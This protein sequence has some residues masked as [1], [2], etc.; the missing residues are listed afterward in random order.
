MKGADV[1]EMP[2]EAA[3]RHAHRLRQRLGLQRRE[4][5]GGQGLETLVQPVFGGELIGHD[6]A[7]IHWCIDR[8]QRSP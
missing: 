1:L 5:A 2:V 4:T 6:V 8:C 7:T 3:A